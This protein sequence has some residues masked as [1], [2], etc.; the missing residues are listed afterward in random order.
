MKKLDFSRRILGIRLGFYLSLLI[1]AGAG[2]WLML[3]AFKTCGCASPH[4]EARQQMGV[5]GRAQ[6][7]AYADAQQFARSIPELGI[8]LPTETEN[9]HYQSSASPESA[10][11]YSFP[12]DSSLKSYSAGVFVLKQF[13]PKQDPEVVTILCE[14]EQPNHN[15]LSTPPY[16]ENEQPHCGAGMN[17]LR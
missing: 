7:A 4:S 17:V 11:A 16:L 5:F 1:G 14:S 8:G 2:V 13:P 10:I 12:R 6:Q 15:A 3:P 9:Y